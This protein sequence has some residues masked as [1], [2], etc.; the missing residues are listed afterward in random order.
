MIFD[1]K[2]NVL[3]ARIY[4]KHDGLPIYSVTTSSGV[5]GRKMTLVKDLNPLPGDIVVVGVINWRERLFEVRGQRKA[6]KDIKRREG[7]LLKR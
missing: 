6:I 7:G 3:N 1:N 2:T 5:F 4:T